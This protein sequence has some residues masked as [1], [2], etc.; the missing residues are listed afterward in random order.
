MM[1]EQTPQHAEKIAA[2]KSKL[3]PWFAKQLP[4][5]SHI[6]IRNFASP[7]I[8]YSSETLLFDLEHEVAGKKM[9]EPL[10]VRLEPQGIPLFSRYDLKLQYRIMETLR[11]SPL[12]VPNTRWF[13]ADTALFG[14]PFYV[15][16][17]VEGK[18]PADNP[19]YHLEGMLVDMPAEECRQLWINAIETMAKIHRLKIEDYDLAFLDEPELGQS[20]IAQHIQLYEN[21]INWGLQRSRFPI[22]EVGLN[23]LRN[24]M[25]EEEPTTLTWGDARICNMIFQGS[26][27][28]AV[29]DWEMAR[30]G[31]PVQDLG[32]WLILD[33][34]LSEALG[35]ERIAATPSETETIAIWE[36]ASGFKADNLLYYKIFAAWCFTMI[37]ARVM[38]REK[39]KGNLPEED[40]FDIDNMASQTLVKLL[41]QAG[42]PCSL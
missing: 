25:P 7:E 21:H 4:A 1:L 12:P 31:N 41:N 42:Q 40:R 11:D 18:V 6:A 2:I 37:L 35:F 23:W 32:Y 28:V 16:D 36:Q 15:M 9:I 38:T 19:P 29:L 20:P 14:A 39:L 5:S 3:V 30:L 10:V 22:L 17:K 34:C 8:G 24:N 33:Y 26:D 27:V 13:E